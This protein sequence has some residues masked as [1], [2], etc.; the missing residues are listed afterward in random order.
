MGSSGL[1]ESIVI[2]FGEPDL[3]ILK[4]NV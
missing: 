3:R 4:S 2:K 1:F